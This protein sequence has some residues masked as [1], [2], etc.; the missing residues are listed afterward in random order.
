[1][2]PILLIMWTAFESFIPRDNN[3][4][5]NNN[6]NIIDVLGDLGSILPGLLKL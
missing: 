6:N 5:N 2:R 1:M 3:N 4:N